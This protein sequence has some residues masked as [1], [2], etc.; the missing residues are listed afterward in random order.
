MQAS[1]PAHEAFHNRLCILLAAF[2]YLCIGQSFF[3]IASFVFKQLAA[4]KDS[5]YYRVAVVFLMA[6]RD[7]LHQVAPYVCVTAAAYFLQ[8]AI[9]TV[10]IHHNIGAFIEPIQK[11][12]CISPG[13]G[14]CIMIQDDGRKPV[15]SGTHQ[16]DI[17]LALWPP[18]RFFQN[19]NRC[20][21]SHQEVSF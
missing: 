8:P 1:E 3:L 14:F 2:V 16:P 9:T 7:G 21:V 5:L 20:F 4:V 18:A 10:T 17:K 11:V 15:L 19:L 12:R 6:L 13:S